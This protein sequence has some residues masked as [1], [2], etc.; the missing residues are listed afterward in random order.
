MK[1]YNFLS[2]ISLLIVLEWWWLQNT[3]EGKKLFPV[4]KYAFSYKSKVVKIIFIYN[5][6]YYS[7]TFPKFIKTKLDVIQE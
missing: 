6:F 7:K 5:P 3:C 2:N 4:K 1:F